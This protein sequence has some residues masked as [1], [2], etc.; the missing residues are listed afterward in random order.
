MYVKATMMRTRKAPAAS[1]NWAKTPAIET[2]SA[3]VRASDGSSSSGGRSASRSRPPSSSVSKLLSRTKFRMRN[4]T[5]TSVSRARSPSLPSSSVPTSSPYNSAA[6][7]FGTAVAARL[8]GST[9][10]RY[11]RAPPGNGG[12]RT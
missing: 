10:V 11:G 5:A 3:T 8:I 9:G 1:P 7:M 6:S 2:V 4:P 12:R